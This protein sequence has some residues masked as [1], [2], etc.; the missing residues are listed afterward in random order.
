MQMLGHGAILPLTGAGQK[1]RRF[2]GHTWNVAGHNAVD[3]QLFQREGQLRTQ[4][5]E[6]RRGVC[7]ALAEGQSGS[8]VR[9]HP[10]HQAVVA[11]LVCPRPDCNKD[12]QGFQDTLQ[13]L[14]V[15]LPDGPCQGADRHLV[16]EDDSPDAFGGR[17]LRQWG[18]PHLEEP[19]PP[20]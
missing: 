16:D 19:P 10:Q 9:L 3:G 11:Q 13:H 1:V 2:I 17:D 6:R 12:G 18:G 5:V 14:C 4:E 15:L 8:A 7:Q 20:Q